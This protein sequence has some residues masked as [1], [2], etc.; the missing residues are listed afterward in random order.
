MA[1]LVVLVGEE[2]LLLVADNEERR[3][4]PGGHMQVISYVGSVLGA[5]LV[6]R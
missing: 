2:I 3:A 5:G 4:H 1:L 6:K